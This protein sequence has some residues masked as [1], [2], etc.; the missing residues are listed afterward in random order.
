VHAYIARVSD[1]TEAEAE[2]CCSLDAA[3]R[4]RAN[5]FRFS[6]DRLLFVI[7][8]GVLRQLLAGYTGCSRDAIRYRV[9]AFGK[10]SLEHPATD[11]PFFNM[12]HS[13]EI[14]LVA[15]SRSHDLGADVE[16]WSDEVECELLARDFF[17]AAEQ[18]A[19]LLLP[20]QQRRASFF[21]CWSRK[22]AYIKAT[23]VGI[24]GGLDYFDVTVS[25]AEPGR[26]LADRARADAND[27]MMVDLDAGHGYAAALVVDR[28]TR[29][30]RTFRVD[31]AGVREVERA[32][33]R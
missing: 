27:W 29:A 9:G 18:T 12:S 1:W 6:G 26:L 14:V 22:E 15:I 30:I 31:R 2:L 17:S 21:A 16:R 4:E 28:A 8:H 5:R 19:F 33:S 24:S 32:P 25:A 7:A 23:G 3:E 11:S 20:E 13:G 10:P